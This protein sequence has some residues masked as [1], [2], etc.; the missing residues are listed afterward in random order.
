MSAPAPAPGKTPK[1]PFLLLLSVGLTLALLVAAVIVTVS[2]TGGHDARTGAAP[3]AGGA[4]RGSNVTLHTVSQRFRL[5]LPDDAK[6]LH[7]LAHSGGLSGEYDLEM[8]F[9][10]TAS[11][12]QHF[13]AGSG[14]PKLSG[15]VDVLRTGVPEAD[16]CRQDAEGLRHASYAGDQV[17]GGADH[18]AYVRGVA[19]DDSDRARPVVALIAMDT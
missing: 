10:T 19:V 9:R 18:G 13:L 15:N 6:D 7:Y 17:A 8:R 12:L 16:P 4:C 14:L 2:L 1:S 11:G 5:K 3:D